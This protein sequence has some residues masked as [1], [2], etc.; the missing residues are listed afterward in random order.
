MEQHIV[1]CVVMGIV[2]AVGISK[3]ADADR[4]TE[5]GANLCSARFG[6]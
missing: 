2:G 1:G 4:G 5:K 3:W 6:W